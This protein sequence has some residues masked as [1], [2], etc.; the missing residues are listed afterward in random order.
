MCDGVVAWTADDLPMILV[1]TES[2]GAYE[3]SAGAARTGLV[4]CGNE[5]G[6]KTFTAAPFAEMVSVAV[7]TL[8][9][10]RP[11]IIAAATTFRA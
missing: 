3:M 8:G 11:A 5:T 2:S 1:G 7:L 9:T 10:A 4:L 6:V